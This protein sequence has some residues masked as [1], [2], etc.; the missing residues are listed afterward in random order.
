MTRLAIVSDLHIEFDEAACGLSNAA[1]TSWSLHLQERNCHITHPRFG[2]DLHD[3]RD[4]ELMILAGDIG[5]GVAS[6]EYAAEAASYCG[7]PVVLVP[8]NHEFYGLHLDTALANMREVAAASRGRVHLLDRDRLDFAA[9]DGRRIAILGATLW[10][11]Y[12][13]NGQSPEQIST[14]LRDAGEEIADHREITYGLRHHAFWPS[15]ARELH[16]AAREWLER[17]IPR[18]RSE[19]DAVIVV[20]HHAPT[21]SGAAEIYRGSRLAPAFASSMENEIGL[22]KP[23]LWIHGHTHF[24]HDTPVGGVRVLSAQRGYIGQEPGAETFTPLVIEL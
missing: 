12:A 5:V 9:S 24:S 11:D 23:D 22:W 15:D 14:A 18:A 17:E 4:C 21:K 6:V 1:E 13:L 7:C 20:S 2:P 8:G 19:T 10:T 3:I 16:I